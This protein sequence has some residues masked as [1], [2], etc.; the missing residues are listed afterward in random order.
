[1]GAPALTLVRGDAC[2]STVTLGMA[3]AALRR[4][5]AVYL[6]AN[7]ELVRLSTQGLHREDA[8]RRF[9]EAVVWFEAMQNRRDRIIAELGG[10]PWLWV[11]ASDGEV[12]GG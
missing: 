10:E 3:L 1:M 4:A 12:V 5:E 7:F 8:R 2:P 11:A 6:E 9:D